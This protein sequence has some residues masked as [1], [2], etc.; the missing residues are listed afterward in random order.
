MPATYAK[1]FAAKE[2]CS[3][4]LGTGIHH[5]VYFKD[6]G[7][8]N[9]PSGQPTSALT[10]GAKEQLDRLAPSGHRAVIHLTITDDYPLAQAFVVI[11]AFPANKASSLS[12]RL[13]K[14]VRNRK[15]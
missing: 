13:L 14:Y 1:R 6:M 4:A 5:G 2:A 15:A 10:G 8:V 9:L 3:K 7:V 11:E 12:I